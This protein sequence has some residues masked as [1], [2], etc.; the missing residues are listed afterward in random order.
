MNEDYCRLIQLCK[1]NCKYFECDVDYNDKYAEQ[2]YVADL[3]KKNP[4]EILIVRFPG[5]IQ[6]NYGQT[7]FDRKKFDI[8]HF[9]SF[10][11]DYDFNEY[12]QEIINL[13][14]VI[15]DKDRSL[16]RIKC[17]DKKMDMIDAHIDNEGCN[18]YF[19]LDNALT[20]M[21]SNETW[22]P[23]DYILPL[24]KT[25]YEGYQLYIPNQIEKYIGFEY[26]NKV[27]PLS[28]TL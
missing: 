17:I 20:T 2:K 23:R 14:K 12:K 24:K 4:N 15:A 9:A 8:F 1:T 27:Y 10:E 28:R 3:L 22:I 21:R 13:N 18:V 7:L 16:E 25:D 5:L 26:K 11:N 19:A 6:I